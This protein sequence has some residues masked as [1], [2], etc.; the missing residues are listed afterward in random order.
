M[1]REQSQNKTW[2]IPAKLVESSHVDQH[3]M[4]GG[5]SLLVAGRRVTVDEL[6]IRIP[7]QSRVHI[8][9]LYTYIC[10]YITSNV[11]LYTPWRY[12]C[13]LSWLFRRG[14]ILP[15]GESLLRGFASNR[16]C[17][18]VKPGCLAT[19]K[20]RFVS[21]ISKS[22]TTFGN[23][24]SR[25]HEFAVSFIQCIHVYLAAY[26]RLASSTTRVTETGL[27]S[28]LRFRRWCL[29]TRECCQI[30]PSHADLSK[31]LVIIQHKL[32]IPD[33]YA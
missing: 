27:A 26:L 11:C 10:T 21:C 32:K 23:T 12:H 28:S 5:S 3:E 8:S 25:F 4:T 6:R 20:L 17:A 7:Q 31:G 15:I 29:G 33:G 24:F 19:R 1:G 22:W 16:N 30:M 9:A 13:W 18:A 2:W 14:F